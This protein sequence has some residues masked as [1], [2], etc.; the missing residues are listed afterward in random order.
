MRRYTIAVFTP[1]EGGF[2]TTQTFLPMATRTPIG[3]RTLRST[4]R[5]A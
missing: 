4:H 2:L 5:L 3:S 1:S